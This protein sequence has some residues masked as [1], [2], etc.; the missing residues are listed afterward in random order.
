[1]TQMYN[2]EEFWDSLSR[3]FSEMYFSTE[4]LFDMM[5]STV[6]RSPSLIYINKIILSGRREK[7]MWQ[8]QVRIYIDLSFDVKNLDLL[9]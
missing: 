8:S 1:M 9:I 7:E 6:I 3:C 5:K 4:T 2:P